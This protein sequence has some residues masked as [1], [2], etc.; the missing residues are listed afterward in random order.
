MQSSGHSIIDQ[1]KEHVKSFFR[2]K[3]DDRFIYHNESH[4][5]SVVHAAKEIAAHYNLKGED[6][7]VLMVAAWFHD[8][9][10]FDDANHHEAM[11]AKLAED[12]LKKQKVD[13]SF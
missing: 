6:Y 2:S 8:I 10:Y 4:T 12:F 13:S 11:G 3:K 5:E 7:D 1:A 9:G